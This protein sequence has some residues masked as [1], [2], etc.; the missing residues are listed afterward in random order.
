MKTI[1]LV[2]GSLR[3]RKSASQTFLSALSRKLVPGELEARIESIQVRRDGAL[4]AEIFEVLAHADAI[5]LAFPLFSYCLPGA[6]IAFLE[7]WYGCAKRSGR[8]GA[9]TRVYAIVNSGHAEPEINEEAIRVVKN[10]CRRMGLRWSFA[11][12]IGGGLLV[13]ACISIPLL[14][15]KVSAAIAALSADIAQEG[16]GEEETILVRPPIPKKLCFFF[17]DLV[18]AASKR[19]RPKAA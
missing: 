6:F 13:A 11:V 19:N 3:G 9:G 10:F 18:L 1:V 12:A 7:N 5:V 15:A 4:T 8:I 2:N 14:N 17:R 16:R